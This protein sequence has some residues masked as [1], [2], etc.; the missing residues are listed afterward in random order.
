MGHLLHD[1]SVSGEPRQKNGKSFCT[2][3]S[4]C[5]PEWMSFTNRQQPPAL[6][7]RLTIL[8]TEC[9]ALNGVANFPK[10]KVVQCN[11]D[12]GTVNVLNNI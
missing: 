6:A 12:Y 10:E 9:A 7:E 8:R 11:F 3:T 1:A 4:E 5:R 2:T